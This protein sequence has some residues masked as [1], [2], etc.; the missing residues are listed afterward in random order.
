MQSGSISYSYISY[1]C[2]CFYFYLYLYRCTHLSAR[3]VD[4]IGPDG[5]RGEG[6]SIN[7]FIR[8]RAVVAVETETVGLGEKLV[9]G[10]GSLNTERLL[11]NGFSKRRR[12]KR[13]EEKQRQVR[14]VS[15]GWVVQLNRLNNIPFLVTCLFLVES[16][17][18]K[19]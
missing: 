9:E 15:K 18:E 5:E 14:A 7:D 6:G 17:E 1:L 16:S 4:D 3:G 19:A 8:R 10:E 13:R 2:F 11:L 12:E